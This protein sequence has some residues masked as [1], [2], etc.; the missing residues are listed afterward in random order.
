[1]DSIMDNGCMWQYKLAVHIKQSR[2]PVA[3]LT[4]LSRSPRTRRSPCYLLLLPALLGAW[5]L[6]L[7]LSAAAALG[8]GLLEDGLG[9]VV[10]ALLPVVLGP[11]RA[12]VRLPG[13]G[14]HCK[15]RIN[16]LIHNAGQRRGAGQGII[17]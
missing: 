10:H 1:M 7:A 2:F 8:R 4:L 17:A 16:T 6:S 13:L 11:R 14:V 15:P 5:L 3:L 12:V 9:V